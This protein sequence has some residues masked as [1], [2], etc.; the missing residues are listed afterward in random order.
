MNDS[1]ENADRL[2]GKQLM[3]NKI[4]IDM[5]KANIEMCV[6]HIPILL[7]TYIT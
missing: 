6:F 2:K 1:L 4:N 3:D 5:W 7:L